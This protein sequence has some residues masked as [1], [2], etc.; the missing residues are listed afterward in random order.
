MA[1]GA[2]PRRLGLPPGNNVMR[3]WW[4]KFK[5]LL[6]TEGHSANTVLLKLIPFESGLHRQNL[7][8][9]DSGQTEH[10]LN[11]EAARCTKKDQVRRALLS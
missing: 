10:E 1:L 6:L 3:A 2:R 11:V 5:L 8:G 9:P 4:R 7:A